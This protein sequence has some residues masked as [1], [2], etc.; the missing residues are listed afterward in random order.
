MKKPPLENCSD[1]LTHL[2]ASGWCFCDLAHIQ[3]QELDSSNIILC[4]NPWLRNHLLTKS[5]TPQYLTPYSVW[6]QSIPPIISF[7]IFLWDYT[8][9][10]VLIIAHGT[11]KTEF[12]LCLYP[13]PFPIPKL[14]FRISCHLF[15]FLFVNIHQW[16]PSF[17]WTASTNSTTS[18]K[19]CPSFANLPWNPV[20]SIEMETNKH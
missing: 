12:A 18:V 16:N 15:P 1:I 3:A 11:Y 4:I 9:S 17:H 14:P 13:F 7:I 2:P 20:S 19:L 5:Q 10:K 8:S 6:Y